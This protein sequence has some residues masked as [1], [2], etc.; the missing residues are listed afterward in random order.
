[1]TT[2]VTIESELKR[3][4][5]LVENPDFRKS[6]VEIAKKLKAKRLIFGTDIDGVYT[7]DPKKDS[8]AKLIDRL[9]ISVM[10]KKTKIHGSL[11]TDVTGGMFGKI[12]EA[13]EAARSGIEVLI[14]NALKPDIIQNAL[15]GEKV[16]GTY[17]I[18]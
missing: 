13:G 17:I 10:N 3:R 14:V 5:D 6:C 9:S 1:M 2:Q 8:K 4:M 7:A 12:Q 15:L 11:N 18:P 16:K